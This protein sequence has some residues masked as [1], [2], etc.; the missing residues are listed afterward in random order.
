MASLHAG[1]GVEGGMDVRESVVWDHAQHGHG[2]THSAW[3]GATPSASLTRARDAGMRME[4]CTR[5]A[6]EK[7]AIIL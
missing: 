2:R 4:V 6:R 1:L 5:G 7:I 3:A